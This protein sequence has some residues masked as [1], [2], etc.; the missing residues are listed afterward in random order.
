LEVS[1]DLVPVTAFVTDGIA[2]VCVL[3]CASD[4]HLDGMRSEEGTHTWS[5]TAA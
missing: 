3:C 2:P 4:T 1:P 5:G